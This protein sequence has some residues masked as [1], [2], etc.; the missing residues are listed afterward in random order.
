M[1]DYVH[2]YSQR[3]GQ[4]LQD[5]AATVRNLLHHDTAYPAGSLVLEVGCGIGAQTITLART[6]PEA[7]ILS[8]DISAESLA[9]AR[10]LIGG[11]GLTNVEFRQADVYDLPF[12]P[13]SFDHVFVCYLLEHLPDPPAALAALKVVLKEG[14]SI[15]VIE[16]DHGSCYW[17]P[18][19]EAGRHVWQCLIDAQ[20][21]LGGDSLIGRRLFPLLDGAGFRDVE[22]SPRMV[23]CD[24][25][26][27]ARVD[28][29][30]RNTIIAM[31]EGAKKHAMAMGLTDEERWAEGIR[32]LNAVADRRD[33]TFCYTFF[34]AV[35]AR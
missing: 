4:R 8:V 32:D 2:G 24:Q 15:T 14:G 9:Q 33:G 3:E 18:D 19:T 31:V 27:P 16:G 5:Q 34:K 20:A 12:A 30:V 11:A 22:V 6:S 7:R 28:G 29:F 21:A 26:L 13:D 35:A 1:V 10:E 25:S 23:Y 17:H